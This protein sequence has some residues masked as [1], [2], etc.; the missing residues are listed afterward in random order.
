[1]RETT[2]ERRAAWLFLFVLGLALALRALTAALVSLQYRKIKAR[3][4]FVR[5]SS[6]VFLTMGFGYVILALS[7][8]FSIVL[9]GLLIAG[10]GLGLLMPNLN[11][12]LVSIIPATMR[13]RAI[14]GLATFIFLGQFFS[15]IIAQPIVQ[16]I[17][18]AGVYGLA[19]GVA[20]L[21]AV[22]L[23]GS[24]FKKSAGPIT[25]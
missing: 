12:W 15:P 13:G 4:S 7:A 23:F 24:K 9:L 17:G 14:G 8:N 3:F 19:G 25:S 18:L 11:V 2:G 16:Q 22:A 1:M 21:L 20:L 5:I 6:L 10:V